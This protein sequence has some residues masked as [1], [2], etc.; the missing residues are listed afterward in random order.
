MCDLRFEFCSLAPWDHHIFGYHHCFQEFQHLEFPSIR[1]NQHL[2]PDLTSN[3][4]FELHLFQKLKIHY[5]YS[6]L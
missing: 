6:V 2:L 4:D 5:K 3:E 1:N